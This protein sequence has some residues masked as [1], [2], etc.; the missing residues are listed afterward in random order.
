MNENIR[1]GKPRIY[2]TGVGG[3]G[4]LTATRILGQAAMIAGITAVG[5][6]VHGMAQRG[7]VVES[8]LLLGG[9]RAPRLDFGEADIILAFEPLEA[10]RG[11]PYLSSGGVVFSAI[12]PL[13]PLGVA[14]GNEQYPTLEEIRGE[15]ARLSPEN[16][17]V[18]SGEL[19]ELAGSRR[20]SGTAL[21]GALCALEYPGF[22][23]DIL[24][25]A[26]RETLPPKSHAA[27][28]KAME[29]GGAWALENK[30]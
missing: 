21:L 22:G 26:I 24:A 7:G 4:T 8:F 23:L 16:Y 14:L 13:A 10:A 25:A 15:V 9:W 29:L 19:A 5:G 3:Q 11:M 2:F 27:N 12:E 30:K 20:A 17:F 6:E 28:I 1:S 18:P